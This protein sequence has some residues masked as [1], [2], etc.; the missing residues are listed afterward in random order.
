MGNPHATTLK[1]S[2]IREKTVLGTT[3]RTTPVH[4]S[5]F[6]VVDALAAPW[7]DNK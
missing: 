5:F 1:T 2:F 6:R 7:H 4:H 3:R